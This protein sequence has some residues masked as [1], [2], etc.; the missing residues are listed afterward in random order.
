MGIGNFFLSVSSLSGGSHCWSEGG[1]CGFIAIEIC[2]GQGLFRKSG[3]DLLELGAVVAKAKVN[4]LVEE[5][6]VQHVPRSPLE[7][8]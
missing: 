8:F 5:D 1:F 6:V 3:E 2:L 7:A 4:P